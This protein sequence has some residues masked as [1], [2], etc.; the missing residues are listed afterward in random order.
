MNA[1]EF[2]FGQLLSFEM[3]KKQ[4]HSARRQFQLTQLQFTQFQLIRKEMPMEQ[5]LLLIAFLV[6]G[7][8]ANLTVMG[9]QDQ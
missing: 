4:K 3:M 8:F 9:S 2:I 7:L 5:Q 6:V 1:F